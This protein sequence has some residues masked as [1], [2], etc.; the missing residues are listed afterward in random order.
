MSDDERRCA[1]GALCRDYRVV[2]GRRQAAQLTTAVGLCDACRR[3]ARRCVRELPT[4]WCKLKLTLGE[5]RALI[6]DKTRRPKPGPK[7]PLNVASDA[8]MGDIVDTASAAAEV[9][10][11]AINA[12][13]RRIGHA[14]GSSGHD[15]RLLA[16]SAAI[17]AEHIDKL[18]TDADGLHL[19][20]RMCML[21]SGVR[22]HLGETQQRERQH[23][24]CPFCGG[25][26]IKEVRDLRGRTS[27]NGTETPEIIRCT[28]CDNGPNRDG[29]WT[30]AEYQWLSKQV[31]SEREEINVLKWLLAEAQWQRD[32]HA[33]LAAEREWALDIVAD[34]LEVN[35]GAVALIGRLHDAVAAA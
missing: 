13:R 4:D 25:V 10:A 11:A 35:G 29:T 27:I 21:H 22:R 14:G 18:A 20:R 24:P 31:L 8:L 30:E 6:G 1:M 34:T 17:V 23:L 32:V 15:Y 33:W 19:T 3:W 12:T 28:S 7:V 26:V 9:V 5:S 2:D 16:D